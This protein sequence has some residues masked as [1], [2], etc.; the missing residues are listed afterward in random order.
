M[1]L[2]HRDRL[3]IDKSV[4]KRAVSFGV[5]KNLFCFIKF[6]V[7]FLWVIFLLVGNKLVKLIL[8]IVD[9]LEQLFH[10]LGILESIDVL[11]FNC[12]LQLSESQIITK[13]TFGFALA[14]FLP[15][16][17]L[18]VTFAF[19]ITSPGSAFLFVAFLFF[20]WWSVKSLQFVVYINMWDC[21]FYHVLLFLIRGFQ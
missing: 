4:I 12:I 14:A 15:K 3:P 13:S 6:V 8:F 1:I 9:S 7:E 19:V 11:V 21:V 20:S 16:L 2:I 10:G 18:I 5:L 17:V